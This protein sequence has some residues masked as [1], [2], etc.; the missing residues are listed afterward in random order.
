MRIFL[1]EIKETATDYDFTQESDWVFE[2]VTQVDEKSDA[3][4]KRKHRAFPSP[5][6]LPENRR[7]VA[8]HFRLIKF[9][10]L[11]LVRGRFSTILQFICSRCANE[12]AFSTEATFSVL[13]SKD[14]ALAGPFVRPVHR[15][16]H[17]KESSTSTTSRPALPEDWESEFF[18]NDLD[19]SYLTEDFI[20]LC[21]IFTEQLYLQVPFQPLCRSECKGMCQNCGADLN[22]GRCACDRILTPEP[23][24]SLKDYK[25]KDVD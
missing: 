4:V 8:L 16:K 2:A 23:F 11:F 12:F 13:F 21:E 9:Q 15:G 10:S 5:S 1:N 24:S 6:V 25:L 17:L 18:Q 3:T 22:I 7:A 19:I 20:D 14:P